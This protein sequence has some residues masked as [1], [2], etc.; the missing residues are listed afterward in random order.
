M[1]RILS[2][3]W[4]GHGI[5]YTVVVIFLFPGAVHN[6]KTNKINVGLHLL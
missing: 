1:V 2:L 3:V 6:E 5:Y 4:Y